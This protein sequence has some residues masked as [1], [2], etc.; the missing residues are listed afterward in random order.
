MTYE[1]MTND[2]GHENEVVGGRAGV[3]AGGP[4][5]ARSLLD[6]GWSLTLRLF[7]NRREISPPVSSRSGP[8]FCLVPLLDARL[9]CS[10]ARN[11]YVP[12]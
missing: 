12:R 9:V 1:L 4:S 2:K 6:H 8:S 3:E 5:N 11:I 10:H 7:E